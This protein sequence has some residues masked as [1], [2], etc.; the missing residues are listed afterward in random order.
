MLQAAIFD[1]DGLLADSEPLWAIAEIE[2]FATVGL[3]LSEDDCRSTRGLAIEE[4]VR[5]RWEQQPWE[6]PSVTELA[7]RI[8]VRVVALARRQAQPMPGAR[9]AVAAARQRGLRVGL[10]TSSAPALAE[11]LLGR[12]GLAHSFD[13]VQSAA[14]LSHPKPHPAVYLAAATALDV[15]PLTCVALEDSL[16]GVIAAKAARMKVIAVPDPAEARDAR[17]SLAD[18]W[19]GSLLELDEGVWGRLGG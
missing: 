12:L 8:L 10:A 14:G 19:L 6:A 5:L 16:S 2:L 15:D 13:C 4:V 17:F 18:V 9:R 3:Q 7:D 1:M 11:A